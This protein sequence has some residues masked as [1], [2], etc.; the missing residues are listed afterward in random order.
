MKLEHWIIVAFI[1][2]C[3]GMTGVFLSG[4]LNNARPSNSAAGLHD[5]V[6]HDL[7]LSKDQE[8]KLEVTEERFAIHKSQLEARLKGANRALAEAISAD[9]TNSPRVQAAIEEFHQA[10]GE[11]QKLTIEHVFEMRALLTEEQ[12]AVFDAEVVRAL[13]ED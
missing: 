2:L 7:N 4:H 6:H 12:A 11:L 5:M 3:A 9:K 13:T 1:A 8:V 10:M